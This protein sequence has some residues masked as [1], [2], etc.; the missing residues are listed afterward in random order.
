MAKSEPIDMALGSWEA[1]CLLG[2]HWTQPKKMAEKGLLTTRVL[3]SPIVKNPDRFFSVYSMDECEQD[4]ADY[5][6]AMRAGG[7]GKR[8]RASVSERPGMLKRLAAVKHKITFG[9]AVSSG[10]ASEI[11]GVHWTFCARLALAGKIVG[12]ILINDRNRGGRCWIFSRASCE[13]NVS[14]ARRLEAAGT[15]KGRK[16]KPA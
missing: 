16:R 3:R 10:D 4:F 9:D 6:E 1:A 15:K 11:L 8:E 14:L 5:D 2:T 13:A 7:T 12:R